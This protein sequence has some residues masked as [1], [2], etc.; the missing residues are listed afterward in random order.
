MT[1][2]TFKTEPRLSNADILEPVWRVFP[3]AH[4][5]DP[6]F[7]AFLALG[8]EKIL[9][10]I[11]P[12]RS[13]TAALNQAKAW[14]KAQGGVFTQR[15]PRAPRATEAAPTETAA[16]RVARLEAELATAYEAVETDETEAA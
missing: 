8:D 14:M 10:A 6:R 12:A 15:P 16:A 7:E 13:K 5:G 3:V 9:E 1:N 2:A 4:A 11:G